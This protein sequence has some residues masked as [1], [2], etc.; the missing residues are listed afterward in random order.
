MAM[1]PVNSFPPPYNSLLQPSN[2]TLNFM[3]NRPTVTLKLFHLS[4]QL[5]CYI[6]LHLWARCY[7]HL[8]NFK[9]KGLDSFPTTGCKHWTFSQNQ[10]F[11]YKRTKLFFRPWAKT[12]FM[13][14]VYLTVWTISNGCSKPK[15]MLQYNAFKI[16]IP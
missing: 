12:Y 4:S 2:W 1:K 3:I 11:K 5:S 10:N 7:I 9:Y 15:T 16:S 8:Q 13:I 6:H 14:I